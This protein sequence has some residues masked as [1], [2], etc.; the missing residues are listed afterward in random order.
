MQ[1]EVWKPVKGYEGRYEVS[2]IGRVRNRYGKIL[3]ADKRL[4]TGYMY[5]ILRDG[6][7]GFHANIHRLVAQAFIPNPQ[8]LPI[9]NH[10]NEIR[11]DNRVEN[12]EWCTQSYN[13]NISSKFK[14]TFRKI[15]QKNLKGEVIAIHESIHIAARSVGKKEGATAI[16]KCARV[17]AG[18]K[19]GFKGI[20]AFGYIWEYHN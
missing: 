5:V 12:L 18:I 8:N 15:I 7:K 13:R 1:K 16:C 19:K 2:S 6:E 9:I 14:K 20:T 11:D 4:G 10:I 17:R 3:S